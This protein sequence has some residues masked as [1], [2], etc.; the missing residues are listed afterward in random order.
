MIVISWRIVLS[1]DL[2]SCETM[3]DLTC[4]YGLVYKRIS[5]VCSL[6]KLM[7]ANIVNS[8]FFD[9]FPVLI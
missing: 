1:L 7:I 2:Y 4:I 6:V 5:L 9:L 3:F 8:Y